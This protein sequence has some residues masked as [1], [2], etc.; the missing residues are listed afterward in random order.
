MPPGGFRIREN[1]MHRR[2]SQICIDQQSL[3][4]LQSKGLGQIQSAEGLPFSRQGAGHKKNSAMRLIAQQRKRRP[5]AAECLSLLRLRPVRKDARNPIPASFF[6]DS[7]T[8]ENGKFQE[9]LRLIDVAKATVEK[10]Q[11]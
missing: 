9:A 6:N 10:I 7:D 2:H 11:A 4:P 8:T 3:L 1:L 5:R